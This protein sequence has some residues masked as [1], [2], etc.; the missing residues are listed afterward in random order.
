M[1]SWQQL[2]QIVKRRWLAAA[3]T[4]GTI[5]TFSVTYALSLPSQYQSR[6]RILI[7]GRDTST[8]VIAAIEAASQGGSPSGNR[9]NNEI[10]IVRSRP[11]V[12]RAVEILN[13]NFTEGAFL[14]QLGV[15]NL[16]KTDILEISFTAATPDIAERAVNSAIAAYHESN[17]EENRSQVSAA[18]TF[19]AEQ[20]PKTELEVQRAE[21]KLQFFKERYQLVNLDQEASAEVSIAKGIEG[22]I[23]S[24]QADI[25]RTDAQI[26]NLA[27]TLNVRSVDEALAT[28]AIGQSPTTSQ[29]L[30]SLE[31]VQQELA[32]ER[33]RFQDNAPNVVA[34]RD[35][36]AALKALLRDRA[37]LVLS[38][39]PG[40]SSTIDPDR[41]VSMGGIQTTAIQQYV[42]LTNQRIGQTRQLEELNRLYAT[43]KR[44]ATD[45][46]R[47][48]QQQRELSRQLAAAQST[49]E[50]LLR[51]FQEATVAEQQNVG[52]VQIIEQASVP[53]DIVGPR[54][55]R[56]MAA[57]LLLGLAMG[58]A[59]A[60]LL[61]KL[62]RRI[63]GTT[64][65][66]DILGV[67]VLGFIP[68]FTRFQ[69]AVP[70]REGSAT[71]VPELV[72]REK[73]N[74]PIAEAFRMLQTNLSFLRSQ[75]KLDVIVVTSSIPREGKSTISA[76]LALSM[77]E[78]GKRVLLIDADMR[79]PS[80]DIIWEAS[81]DVGLSDVL[82]GRVE[83]VEAIQ[84]LTPMLHLL[85][86][87][88]SPSNPVALLNSPY[89]HSLLAYGQSH[90]DTVLIDTP[91]LALAADASILG[92]IAD[93]VLM[94]VRVDVVDTGSVSYAKE[95]VE[96][97]GQD[98]L[99]MIVNASR[100][101]DDSYAYYY[102]YYNSSGYYRSRNAYGRQNEVNGSAAAYINGAANGSS[103]G[104]NSSNGRH[105][106]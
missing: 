52:N 46:P 50:T 23:N 19:I 95:I 44:R 6:G 106:H 55:T 81:N 53:I 37:A 102:S 88:T 41:L 43:Y 78:L 93:G 12:K 10:E 76:N 86:A 84:P 66:K 17:I 22:Q 94:V 15:N 89:L 103:N 34:L 26:A 40:G 98:L 104:T 67:P 1:D 5:T 33:T 64:T 2:L 14:A 63:K 45:F 3:L 51:K 72:M 79:R 36:E 77:A 56:N 58:G 4:C 62:D 59:T 90:Y 39:E 54:R 80:Q 38:E 75:R 30:A 18:R 48:E 69:G 31:K 82:A 101:R 73:P 87:G 70:Q 74:S 27:A 60:Y 21:Q 35:K 57:G 16:P 105:L 11:V 25:A 24:L 7:R 49:Y 96:Q 13:A 68:S 83:I 8:S 92:R 85:P 91:P 71:P 99:G 29:I 32:V 97:S 28:A 100:T 61:E 20:L 9:L 47:L 42:T 65:A